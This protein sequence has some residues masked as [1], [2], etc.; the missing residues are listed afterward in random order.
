MKITKLE[1]KQIIRECLSES[2]TDD[3]AKG[4]PRDL[5]IVKQI[6]QDGSVDWAHERGMST[7]SANPALFTDLSSAK[8]FA[9]KLVQRG[10]QFEIYKIDINTLQK[11]G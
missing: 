7:L 3:L 8:A 2:I 6:D 1:L 11:V 4:L 9:S 5:Y 10:L